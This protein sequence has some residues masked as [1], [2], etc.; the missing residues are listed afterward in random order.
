MTW[1]YTYWTFTKIPAIIWDRIAKATPLMLW[2]Q[3]WQGIVFGVPLLFALA[4]LILE[5]ILLPIAMVRDL[6]LPEKDVIAT[7]EK[8]ER[9]TK[10]CLPER[11]TAYPARKWPKG[12]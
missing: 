9:R 4:V 7:E 8:L 11:R 3:G 2:T 10:R 1:P 12:P 6:C 5:A